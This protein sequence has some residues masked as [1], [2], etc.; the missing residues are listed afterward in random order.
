MVMY[1]LGLCYADGTGTDKDLK[2]AF[3]SF[4]NAGEKDIDIAQF[5]VGKCYAEGLGTAKDIQKAANWYKKS[6]ILGNIEARNALALLSS[7]VPPTGQNSKS[8]NGKLSRHHEAQNSSVDEE[9]VQE[10]IKDGGKIANSIYKVKSKFKIKIKK[11][12][13]SSK[14]YDQESAIFDILGH[15]FAEGTCK[16]KEWFLECYDQFPMNQT[17]YFEFCDISLHTFYESTAKKLPEGR[18]QFMLT[19]LK[20]QIIPAL[21]FLHELNIFHNDIKANNILGK[22]NDGY[23]VSWKITDSIIR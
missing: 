7:A 15:L 23:Y 2:R 13:C 18:E 14:E 22:K 1:E 11:V 17:I 19:A 4:L 16:E 5:R 21:K 6:S 12:Y 8:P 9:V 10:T 3:G 20:T